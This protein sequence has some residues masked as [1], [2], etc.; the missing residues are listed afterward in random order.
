MMSK[1]IFLLVVILGLL[2]ATSVRFLSNPR[3]LDSL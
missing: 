1:G 3:L 2:Y